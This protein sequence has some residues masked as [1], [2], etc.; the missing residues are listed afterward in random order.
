MF[1]DFVNVTLQANR[2]TEADLRQAANESP[3]GFKAAFDAWRTMRANDHAS[4]RKTRI[5]KGR[6]RKPKHDEA[7]PEPAKQVPASVP[8]PEADFPPGE[9]DPR[10]AGVPSESPE[11]SELHVLQEV[12]RGYEQSHR[13]YVLEAKKRAGIAHPVS[14][15]GYRRL[16]ECIEDVIAEKGAK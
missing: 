15:D 4:L 11:E 12:L 6:P 3:E 7:P 5:D 1:A 2:T 14:L 16:V 10:Q 9:Q 13:H 8:P